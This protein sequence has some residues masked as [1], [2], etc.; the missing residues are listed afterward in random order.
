MT[1]ERKKSEVKVLKV[2]YNQKIIKNKMN[3]TEH[4]KK[5]LLNYMKQNEDFARGRLRYNSS[6]KKVLVSIYIFYQYTLKLL[7]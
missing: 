7:V 2:I 3:I 5:I 1:I 6:N 4:Q